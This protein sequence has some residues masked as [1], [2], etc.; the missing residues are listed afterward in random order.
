MLAVDTNVLVR[1]LARDDD[2]RNA[3]VQ[4]ALGLAGEAKVSSLHVL[5]PT[6]TEALLLQESGMML[7]RSVQFH[8]RN[9]GYADFGAFLGTMSHD[10]RKKIKQV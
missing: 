8:W 4:A 2:G 9:Q 3:L 1:L 6:E 10:K 5:F 7:R